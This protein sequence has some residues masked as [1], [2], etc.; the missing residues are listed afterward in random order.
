MTGKQLAVYETM[1]NFIDAKWYEDKEAV[2]NILKAFQITQDITPLQY[3]ELSLLTNSVY[4][5]IST[6]EE[7]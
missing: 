1:K 5:E 2:F 4:S 6:L 3:T 7:K